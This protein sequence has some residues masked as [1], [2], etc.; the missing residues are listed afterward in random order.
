MAAPSGVREITAYCGIDVGTQGVRAVLLGREGTHLASAGAAV[1]DGRREGTR[2]EQDPA[3][4]WT[5]LVTAVRSAV[6]QAGPGVVVEA[7]SLDATSGTVLVQDADGSARGPALMY[8]DA[9]ASAQAER[10]RAAGADLWDAL[11]YRMQESWALPKLMWLTESGAVGTGDRLVHQSDHLVGRLV[12]TAVATDTSHAL[13]SGVDLRTGEWPADVLAELGLDAAA[14][15]RVVLPG[16]VIGAVGTE[17]AQATGLSQGTP[18]RAGMTDGCAAQIASRA[19]RPGSWSSALGT[20]LTIKGSTPSLVHDRHG[21]VYCHRNPD[22]GWLPGGASSTGAGVIAR[23]FPGNPEAL[24]A[25]TAQ[26][27]HLVPMPG[28]TYALDGTGERFPFVAPK[29]HGF[30]AAQA[31]V[32]QPARFAALCQSVAYV[33]RL[34][35]DVLGVLGADV[36]GPVSLSGGAARNTWW[37]QLR[38]DVLGRTTVLPESVQAATGM[39]VLAAAEPGRL[40]E[41]AERMVRVREEYAPDQERGRSLRPGYE[42]FLDEL[43]DRGWLDGDLAARVLADSGATR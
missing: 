18:V 5:A 26:A 14:L 6:D 7:V 25:L 23:T 31:T 16:T 39:A 24:D 11:G 1:P 22:G 21:A 42:R 19:L 34:A 13:K 12:G 28:V 43:T 33:E 4:W 10:A 35:Y 15:P 41:T 8:D 3:R 9:R 36:T 40:A 2:H 38:T 37:N 27:G 17:A 30:L 29:A 32:S 20:T